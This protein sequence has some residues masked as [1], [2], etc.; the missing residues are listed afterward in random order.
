LHDGDRWQGFRDCGLLI[1]DCGLR[2]PDGVSWQM[3]GIGNSETLKP[4]L[5][6][7]SLQTLQTPETLKLLKLLK[8]LKRET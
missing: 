8:L 3:L 1:G 4:C 5:Q 6:Q 7:A 2:L